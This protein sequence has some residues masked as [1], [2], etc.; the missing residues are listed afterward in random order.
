MM[1][2]L[3]LVTH[4][5]IQCSLARV[6]E[7]TGGQLTDKGHGKGRHAHELRL[8]AR[9]AQSGDDRWREAVVSSVRF[10]DVTHRARH[11]LG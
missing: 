7:M 6:V 4:G 5:S 8:V 11:V 9:V 3:T 10:R 2:R 1:T